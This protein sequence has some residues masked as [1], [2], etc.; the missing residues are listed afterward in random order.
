MI[1]IIEVGPEDLTR[2]LK[3]VVPGVYATGRML[4]V[5]PQMVADNLPEDAANKVI[6]AGVGFMEKPIFELFLPTDERSEKK[7]EV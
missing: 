6:Y 4:Q 3:L 7:D 2:N 1:H 5:T